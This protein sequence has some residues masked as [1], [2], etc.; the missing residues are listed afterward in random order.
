MPTGVETSMADFSTIRATD[1]LVDV[2]FKLL[3]YPFGNFVVRW[4]GAR[5]R[6]SSDI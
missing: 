6:R 5:A 2:S 3:G 4:D 1:E